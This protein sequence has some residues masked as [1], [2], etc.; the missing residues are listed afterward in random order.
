MHWILIP[1]KHVLVPDMSLILVDA[2]F[3]DKVATIDILAIA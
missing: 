2:R 3:P 1:W